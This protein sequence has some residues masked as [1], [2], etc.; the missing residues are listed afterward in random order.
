[1]GW[2]KNIMRNIKVPLMKGGSDIQSEPG[3]MIEK[4]FLIFNKPI[5]STRSNLWQPPTDVYETEENIIVKLDI[6]GVKT[7]DVNITFNDNILTICGTRSSHSVHS[8]TCFYQ[9]EIRYGLFER[10]IEVPKPIIEGDIIAKFSD[11]FLIITLP[12][13]NKSITRSR[14]AV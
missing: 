8:K 7:N 9:V 6:S 11:G 4:E 5:V 1:M 12:K 10:K 13:T 3:F 2:R 14:F